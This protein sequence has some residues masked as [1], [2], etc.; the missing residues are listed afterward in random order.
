MIFIKA[1]E[2]KISEAFFVLYL[3]EEAYYLS[4]S[5]LKGSIVSL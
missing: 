4:D 3:S 1:F 5:D 2:S